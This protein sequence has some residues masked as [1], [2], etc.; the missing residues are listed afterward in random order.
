MARS[1]MDMLSQDFGLSTLHDENQ[2]ALQQVIEARLQGVELPH[3]EEAAPT[4]GKVIDLMAALENSVRAAKESR[5]ERGAAGE[6]EAEVRTLPVRKT[7]KKAAP[8]RKATGSAAKK[9]AADQF[10]TA[11]TPREPPSAVWICRKAME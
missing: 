2:E 1:L 6:T 5:G 7:A 11:M 3:E 10:A 9:T 8:A 4:G